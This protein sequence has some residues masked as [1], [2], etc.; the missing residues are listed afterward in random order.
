[1]KRATILERWDGSLEQLRLEFLKLEGKN[2]TLMQLLICFQSTFVVT[3]KRDLVRHLKL[4]ESRLFC[5]N[6]PVV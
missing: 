2:K 1:M 4:I 5:L 6:T 3:T